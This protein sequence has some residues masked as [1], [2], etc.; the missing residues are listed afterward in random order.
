VRNAAGT[1]TGGQSVFETSVELRQRLNETFGLVAFTDAGTVGSGSFV[2]FSKQLSM[3]AGLGVR[4]YTDLGPIRLDVAVPINPG[5][6]DPKFGVFAGIG[7][8]F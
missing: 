6:D 4:Y 1:L 8:S 7:Q 5:T 2:D 3:S